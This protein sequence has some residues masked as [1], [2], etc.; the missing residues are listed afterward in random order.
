MSEAILSA[1]RASKRF[2]GVHALADVSME[3]REGEIV[4]LIGP[5]GSGKT[6][7]LNV[8]SGVLRPTGGRIVVSG[9][10]ATGRRPHDFA[11]LGVGRT[12]QQVRLFTNMTVAENV[13]IGAIARGH[14]A[15]GA[16]ELL[17]RMGLETDAERYA[18]TLAYG[19]QRRVEIARAL[20]GAPRFLLLDEPAAG[21]NEAESDALLSTI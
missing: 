1:E 5:N 21:M 17:Q 12:F 10:D 8:A 16:E 7:L 19:Q 15:A 6:T 18:G 2:R 3:V 14:T 4:G 13:R 9:T 11:R 20:A